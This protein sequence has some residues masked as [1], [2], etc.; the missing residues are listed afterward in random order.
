M[1]GGMEDDESPVDPVRQMYVEVQTE[2]PPADDDAADLLAAS[3]HQPFFGQHDDAEGDEEDEDVDLAQRIL[4]GLSE[5]PVVQQVDDALLQFDF[6][7]IEHNLNIV[8]MMSLVSITLSAQPPTKVLLSAENEYLLGVGRSKQGGMVTAVFSLSQPRDAEVVRRCWKQ[9]KERL[10]TADIG[11]YDTGERRVPTLPGTILLLRNHL[12]RDNA[13]PLAQAQ[14]RALG[15]DRG[16]RYSGTTI[17]GPLLCSFGAALASWTESVFIRSVHISV[18]SFGQKLPIS[19]MFSFA[20]GRCTTR[21]VPALDDVVLDERSFDNYYEVLW[22]KYVTLDQPEYEFPFDFADVDGFNQLFDVRDGDDHDVLDRLWA[23]DGVQHGLAALQQHR[24]LQPDV[25]PYTSVDIA[26]TLT[27]PD[28]HLGIDAETLSNDVIAALVGARYTATRFWQGIDD[29]LTSL[30]ATAPSRAL[31]VGIQR[32]KVYTPSVKTFFRSHGVY[33]FANVLDTPNSKLVAQL[34]DDGNKLVEQRNDTT[35]ACRI[36]FTL[37]YDETMFGDWFIA[38]AL[39]DIVRFGR[40]LARRLTAPDEVEPPAYIVLHALNDLCSVSL[41]AMDGIVCRSIAHQVVYSAI[42]AV[43]ATRAAA[44]M[45]SSANPFAIF[46]GPIWAVHFACRAMLV[47]LGGRDFGESAHTRRMEALTKHLFS[48][49]G[50]GGRVSELATNHTYS[51]AFVPHAVTTLAV[52]AK[53]GRVLLTGADEVITNRLARIDET[54]TQAGID[55][56][57]AR[58]LAVPNLWRCLSAVGDTFSSWTCP[59]DA[60]AWL[61]YLYAQGRRLVRRAVGHDPVDC[62]SLTLEV[63]TGARIA[64]NGARDM[65]LALAYARFCGVVDRLGVV[66]GRLTMR[67]GSALVVREVPLSDDE[68]VCDGDVVRELIAWAESIKNNGHDRHAGRAVASIVAGYCQLGE[69]ADFDATGSSARWYLTN[70][71]T[72]VLFPPYR[73]SDPFFFTSSSNSISVRIT[74]QA[75]MASRTEQRLDAVKLERALLDSQPIELMKCSVLRVLLPFSD[76]EEEVVVQAR[77]ARNAEPEPLINTSEGA[78]ETKAAYM[79][80]CFT[81]RKIVL[82]DLATAIYD[83]CRM[84]IESLEELWE[85]ALAT[86]AEQ[87]KEWTIRCLIDRLPMVNRARRTDSGTMVMRFRKTRPA[88]MTEEEKTL[89]SRFYATDGSRQYARF[90][91]DIREHIVICMH[92]LFPTDMTYEDA[93]ALIERLRA[94]ETK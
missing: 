82:T 84:T 76:G 63:S 10:G 81:Q 8:D 17:S 56:A 32:F 74:R 69:W 33:P 39:A 67:D 71:L 14:L 59:T 51:F 15:L 79:E 18:S 73:R 85:Q 48:A 47:V 88:K 7:G 43:V 6:D 64:A 13:D 1:P 23:R 86:V 19:P 53:A 5:I 20:S 72:G 40:H 29:R 27:V 16:V 94:S 28:H 80:R 30:T 35:G 3:S 25:H 36:E 92:I 2:Y 60:V 54:V 62:E 49:L 65:V 41:I 83:S 26:M 93:A 90:G 11:L 22:P 45:T 68:T 77:D 55:F 61:H 52:L 9:D 42:G 46:T 4:R 38:S 58:F 89:F 91:Y 44:A 50:Y 37:T 57:S 66:H 31:H 70:A 87:R 12:A 34:M 75:A 24:L 78:V 21:H